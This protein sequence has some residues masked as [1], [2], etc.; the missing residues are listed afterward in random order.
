MPAAY[1]SGGAVLAPTGTGASQPGLF[2]PEIFI[3]KT[4]LLY[5]DLVRNDAGY[6]GAVAEGRI[7]AAKGERSYV[8]VHVGHGLGAGIVIDGQLF[9]G[10]KGFSG[11]IGHCPI[12]DDGPLCSCGLRGCLETLASGK[13]IERIAAEAARGSEPTSLSAQ[14]VPDA[15][16]VLEAAQAGDAVARRI[17]REV[18]RQLG[19][20]LSYLI[21]VLDPELVVLG[22]R[23]METSDFI[24]EGARASVARH[25]FRGSKVEV[26]ASTLGD[27]AGLMGSV[28]SAMDQA[29]RSYRIVATG[30]GLARRDG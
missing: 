30:D 10:T 11:E 12:L 25:T 28:I 6:A 15:A 2:V 24:L 23:V 16:A 7:G 26:V 14:A 18:G 4:H 9:S 13:A 19:V 22:G 29:V 5:Y 8:W 27:R 1:P 3:P 21:N 17:L 20:G